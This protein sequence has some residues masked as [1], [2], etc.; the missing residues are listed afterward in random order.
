MRDM[1]SI[2]LTLLCAM[3]IL[4]M[5]YLGI[6]DR[7]KQ[8]LRSESV[9]ERARYENAGSKIFY[10]KIED[11]IEI[12]PWN[13]FP[14]D[15]VQREVEVTPIFLT[16]E[17]FVE[18]Y[19]PEGACAIEAGETETQPGSAVDMAESVAG[20]A[21]VDSVPEL[22]VQGYIA[23]DYYFSELISCET[24]VDMEEVFGWFQEKGRHILQNMIMTE[25]V[26]VGTI[27]F[28]RGILE[29]CGKK[30]QVR[31]ACSDWNIINFVCAEYR[32]GDRR[33]QK[34]WKEGKKKMVEALEESE[35]SFAKYFAYMSQLNDMGYPTIYLV[36]DVYEN[37]YL[38]GFRWLEDIMQGNG[39]DEELAKGIS[40]WD[41]EWRAIFQPDKDA[42]DGSV[43]DVNQE[44]SVDYSYQVVELK[45]MI[46]LLV[47]G[48]AAMGLYFDPINR[49]FCGYNFFYQY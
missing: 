48:D 8:I 35:E 17:S 34:A 10:G 1:K 18:Q 42:G 36:D 15:R 20:D 9:P 3:V 33:E 28:Y 46:L 4:G 43:Q 7:G 6:V 16:E 25:S 27:Y 14:E 47:Q 31:I 23:T 32:S 13:Y 29:L 38:Y 11:D 41:K 19:F 24:G 37:A 39:E 49:K 5:G 26:S 45:D 44:D 12:F 2:V 22:R 40:Q 21:L 30:F